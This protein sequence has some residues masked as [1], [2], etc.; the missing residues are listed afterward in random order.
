MKQFFAYCSPAVYAARAT[1][2]AFHRQLRLILLLSAL[3]SLSQAIALALLYLLIRQLTGETSEP[4]FDPGPSLS[5]LQS[6]PVL[7][8]LSA[9][10]LVAGIQIRQAIHRVTISASQASGQ[11]AAELGLLRARELSQAQREP[12][13]SRKQVKSM[14]LFVTRDVPFACGFAA[15]S[16]T[17][18]AFNLILVALLGAVMAYISAVLTAVLLLVGALL[19]LYL[20]RSFSKAVR[21]SD[22]RSANI[23]NYRAEV[24]ALASRISADTDDEQATND[25]LRTL[26]ATSNARQQL[27][28]RLQERNERQ[29]G[30]LLV[31]YAYPIAIIAIAIIYSQLDSFAPDITALALYFLLTRQVIISL[32]SCGNVFM[33]LSKHHGTLT[34]FRDFMRDGRLPPKHAARGE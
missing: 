10:L 15:R 1:Y 22:E 19:T 5:M 11:R 30:G 27:V 14:V 33:S 32:Y 17:T 34:G 6:V 26:L 23:A 9:L 25:S 4:L 29:T 13:L 24:D 12:P 31:E 28:S 20:S 8:C 21:S 16:A 7:T 2:R 3:Y 18:L